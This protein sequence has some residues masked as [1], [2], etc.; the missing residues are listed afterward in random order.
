M[1]QQAQHMKQTPQ[2]EI[3]QQLWRVTKI[4]TGPAYS[5][6]IS[7]LQK[8]MRFLLGENSGFALVQCPPFAPVLISNLWP[9]SLAS[10]VSMNG[11]NGPLHC[12]V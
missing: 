11:K 1:T 3:K 4:L 12:L 5:N 6:L 8:W 7:I 10:C 9:L 2:S